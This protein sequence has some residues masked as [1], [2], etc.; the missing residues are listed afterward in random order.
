MKKKASDAIDLQG[1]GILVTRPSPLGELSCSEI[2]KAGGKPLH[3][4]T[5]LVSPPDNPEIVKRQIMLLDKQDWLIFISPLAVYTAEK[6]IKE[7]WPDFPTH[8][9]VAAIGG[10]TA[11]ALRSVHLPVHLFPD[12]K[13][14][15]EGLL[16]LPAFQQ[17]TGK[18][19][20]IFSGEEGREWLA[21]TLKVRGAIVS[22]IFSFRRSFPMVDVSPVLQLIENHEIDVI[23]ISSGEGLKNLLELLEPII[24]H[25]QKIPLL[26]VS[27]RL[28]ALA[29][30][31][32]FEKI[33]LAKNAGSH[34]VIDAL[35][36]FLKE[37]GIKHAKSN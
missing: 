9:N 30:G 10:G 4:P 27:E 7:L 37:K 5:I 31:L 8:V 33:L 2:T 29:K 14:S 35:I 23:A 21:E 19:I 26:V 24:I 15:A 34:A 18:R 25:L 3:F 17:V 28:E 22:R 16:E 13:W 11:K 12:E 32:G 36:E 6:S 20:A 1:L